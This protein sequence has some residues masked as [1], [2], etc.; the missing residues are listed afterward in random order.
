MALS[1]DSP[2]RMRT[3]STRSLTNIFPSPTWPVW[4]ARHDRIQ[5]GLQFALGNDDFQLD[6]REEIDGIFGAAVHLGV[7][8]LTAEAADFG[9][10]HSRD[11]ALGQRFLYVFELVM[12]DDRFHFFHRTAPSVVSFQLSAGDRCRPAPRRALAVK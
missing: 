2:V 9:D 5:H 4:A 1:P 10:G 3:T 6:L 11:A 7:A 8:L 12:P